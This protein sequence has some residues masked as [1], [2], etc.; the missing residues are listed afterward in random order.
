MRMM[1]KLQEMSFRWSRCEA[2]WSEASRWWLEKA[3]WILWENWKEFFHWRKG[4]L[5]SLEDSLVAIATLSFWHP[6]STQF[7]LGS[8]GRLGQ[9]WRILRRSFPEK[10]RFSLKMQRSSSTELPLWEHWFP[11]LSTDPS[12][13]SPTYKQTA[14]EVWMLQDVLRSSRWTWKNRMRFF[15]FLT[16]IWVNEEVLIIPLLRFWV[17]TWSVFIRWTVTA[18]KTIFRGN[19][20]ESLHLSSRSPHRH[21]NEQNPPSGSFLSANSTQKTVVWMC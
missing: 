20:S 9:L 19:L 13:A 8:S 1:V 4:S 10:S 7:I 5:S 21:D 3:L 18:D 15:F 6:K 12:P 2:M 14:L 16:Q 17:E 11:F